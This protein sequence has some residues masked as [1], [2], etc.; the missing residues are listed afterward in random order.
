MDQY[1]S[2][3][4][5]LESEVLSEMASTFFGARKEVEI[6]GEDLLQRVAELR[7]HTAKVYARVIF[8]RTLLLGSEGEAAFFLALGV[9]TQFSEV[10]AQPSSR[11][12]KPAKLPFGLF[13][14][15]RY[16]KALLLAYDEVR[17]ACE[18]Y[19]HGQ[20]EDDPD[21]KGRKRMSLNFKMVEELC[22]HLNKRISKL[23]NEMA[24]SSVLQYARSIG[25]IEQ[26]GQAAIENTLGAESLDKGLTLTPVEFADFK[27]WQAPSLPAGPDCEGRLRAFATDFYNDHAKEIQRVLS[28]LES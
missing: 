10:Q 19:M 9:A 16:V 1:K 15:S 22:Q 28:G 7:A 11:A 13:A 27:L 2:L 3:A 20:Y 12:W 21:N 18:V 26:P 24:P 5:A 14:S 17:Q 23:N 8:L 4:V 6:Q 25:N